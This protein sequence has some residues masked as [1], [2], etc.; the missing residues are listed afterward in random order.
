MVTL[1]VTSRTC[2]SMFA[3]PIIVADSIE[4]IE[5]DFGEIDEELGT[6]HEI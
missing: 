1:S 4:Q 5:A 6:V 2:L 3:S